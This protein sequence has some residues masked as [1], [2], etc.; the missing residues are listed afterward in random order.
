[1]T[2]IFTEDELAVVAPVLV[3]DSGHWDCAAWQID[4]TGTL[5]CACGQPLFRFESLT[6][7]DCG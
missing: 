3:A 7:V 1:M 6:A 5:I 4:D 2:A